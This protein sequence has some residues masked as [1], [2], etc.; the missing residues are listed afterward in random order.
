MATRAMGKG[1]WGFKPTTY[2]FNTCPHLLGRKPDMMY[3]INTP[4]PPY[5]PR[6]CKQPEAEGWAWVHGQSGSS[7]PIPC[8]HTKMKL[9]LRRRILM[10]MS[11]LGRW[12][13][14]ELI[15]P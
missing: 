8:K 1:C 7:L 14:V 13:V 10:T 6:Y 9:V 4:G 3:M 5:I 15:L 11:N 12:G 2:T